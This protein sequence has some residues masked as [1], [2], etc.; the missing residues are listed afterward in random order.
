M[1]KDLGFKIAVP[2]YGTKIKL[3]QTQS[4]TVSLERGRHFKRDVTLDIEASA[5]ISVEPTTVLIK[6]S[7]RPEVQLR[8]AA[9]QTAA[10]GEY[11]VSVKGVPETG[12]ATSTTFTV[13]VVSL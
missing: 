7:E 9:A 4:V 2:T 3:G 5:G 6:S 12:E 8:I 1:T 10:L 13:K 11:P